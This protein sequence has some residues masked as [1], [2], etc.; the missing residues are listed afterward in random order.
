MTHICISQIIII[1]SES[2]LSPDWCQAIIR[3][4][5]GILLFGPLGRNFSEISVEIYSFSFKKMHLKMSGKWRPS[6]LGLNVLTTR[7]S[8]ATAQVSSC[9]WVNHTK[10]W[11]TT[12]ITLSHKSHNAQIPYLTMHHFVTEMCTWVQRNGA[13]WDICPMH[14]G[15]CEMS[16]ILRSLHFHN[17]LA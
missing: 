4:N 15:V 5:D 1:G 13:L 10:G 2:G 7:A 6:C 14:R 16:I 9:S 3:N 8:V 11:V 17:E 12:R